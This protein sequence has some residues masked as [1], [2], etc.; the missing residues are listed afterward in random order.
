LQN[1]HAGFFIAAKQQA[2]LLIE[3]RSLHVQLT[4]GTSFGLEI[5]VM[6]VQPIDA[7]V[8]FEIGIVE[9]APDGGAANFLRMR[10]VDDGSGDVVEGPTCRRLTMFCGVA[11]GGAEYINPLRGGKKLGAYQSA[12]DLANLLDRVGRNALAIVRRCSDRNPVRWR[13]ADWKD[14]PPWPHAK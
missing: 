5:R 7:F 13:S 4:D 8:G 12:E 9:D 1:L 2:T 14:R 3:V 6:A 11:G 10:F